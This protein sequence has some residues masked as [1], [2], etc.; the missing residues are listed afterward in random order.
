MPENYVE[1]ARLSDLPRE[2]S[3][4][5]TV[6]GKGVALFNVDGIVY[7]MEDALPSSQHVSRILE[8]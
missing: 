8:I 5:V 1:A 7:A 6:A 3:T 2:R 4:S